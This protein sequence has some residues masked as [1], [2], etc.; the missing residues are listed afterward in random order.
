MS[1]VEYIA[2]P[3]P[4]RSFTS[5]V[6]HANGTQGSAIILSNLSNNNFAGYVITVTILSVRT[7]TSDNLILVLLMQYS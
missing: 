4:G 7:S 2:T 5:K 3:L 6:S 1:K